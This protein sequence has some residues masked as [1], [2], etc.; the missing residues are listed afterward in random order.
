MQHEKCPIC[1]GPIDKVKDRTRM[2][3]TSRLGRELAH[4]LCYLRKRSERADELEEELSSLQDDNH[5]L[6]GENKL[7]SDEVWKERHKR[8]DA[9]HDLEQL[10]QP[11]LLKS[12]AHAV[13][14]RLRR[15]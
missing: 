5:I 2:I 14:D 3:Q 8:W 12:L 13:L 10:R 15:R 9:E 7:L 1:S 11:P 6:E 4:E